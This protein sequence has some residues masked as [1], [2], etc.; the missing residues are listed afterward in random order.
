MNKLFVLWSTFFFSFG[1]LSAMFNVAI[2]KSLQ[3]CVFHFHNSE[4]KLGCIFLRSIDGRRKAFHRRR[5]PVANEKMFVWNATVI[6]NMWAEVFV[7]AFCQNAKRWRKEIQQN[8]WTNKCDENRMRM[9][10]RKL[11]EYEWSKEKSL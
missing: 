6:E 4:E 10:G 2:I 3:K 7:S 5:K 8:W 11:K 9:Y 1:L